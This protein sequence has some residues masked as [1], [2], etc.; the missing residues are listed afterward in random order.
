MQQEQKSLGLPQLRA[1]AVFPSHLFPPLACMTVRAL[2]KNPCSQGRIM[3][4]HS[5]GERYHLV[6]AILVV[7]TLGAIRF[8][9][10]M[11]GGI[12]CG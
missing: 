12:F 7:P 8:S 9:G 6:S 1:I 2:E 10:D 5:R 4:R 11:G 3:V